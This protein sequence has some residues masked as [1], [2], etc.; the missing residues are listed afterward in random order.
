MNPFDVFIINPIK[1]RTRHSGIHNSRSV[2]MLLKVWCARETAKE[3]ITDRGYTHLS[4]RDFKTPADMNLMPVF[5]YKWLNME[6]TS[7]CGNKLR[8]AFGGPH[9]IGIKLIRKHVAAA[10]KDG[11]HTLIFVHQNAITNPAQREI[12]SESSPKF[13]IETFHVTDLSFNVTR[14]R[15]NPGFKLLSRAEKTDLLTSKRWSIKDLPRLLMSDPI[16]RY[17]GYK[18]GCLVKIEGNSVEGGM[19]VSYRVVVPDA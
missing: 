1:T 12:R 4:L 5:E 8:V 3:M 13:S 2:K 6:S 7:E 11:I 15:L 9:K 19:A 14:H 10:Q 16:S 18:P 17:Y